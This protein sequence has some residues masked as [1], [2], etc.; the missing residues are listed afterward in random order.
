[1]VVGL[2]PSKEKGGLESI[3]E[4]ILSKGLVISG[5]VRVVLVDTELLNLKLV[6]TLASFETGQKY[7]MKLPL[8]G[9]SLG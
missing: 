1:M 6:L 8:R 9:T 5:D 4:K 3:L 7:A 2:T